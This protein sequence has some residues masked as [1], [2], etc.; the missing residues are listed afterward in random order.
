MKMNKFS[1]FS[2]TAATAA[3]IL[4]AAPLKAD[5]SEHAGH[6]HGTA[7]LG[8]CLQKIYKIK[9]TSDFVKVE[10]LIVTHEGDPS[11]EIEVR[12]D[13]GVEWEFMCEANDGSIYEVEQEVASPGDPKFKSNT[14][15][16]EQ[17]ALKTVAALYPGEVKE[18]EYEI[19]ANGEPTYEI[20]VVDDNDTEWKLEVDAA[21]GQI[22]E[23]HIEKWEI[24]EE[25][26]E[27]A[28]K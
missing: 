3:G 21:S 11:F 2:L 25:S 26:D 27:R 12:G 8:V 24:G 13:N 18:V 10:Y 19:E 22:I 5:D 20:D 17:Q 6:D 23:V 14:K 28:S 4:V 16:S 7:E 1:K 9:G 15:V